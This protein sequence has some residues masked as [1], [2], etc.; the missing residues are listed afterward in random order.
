MYFRHEFTD[1]ADSLTNEITKMCLNLKTTEVQTYA[2]N[3]L[4]T[5]RHVS[6]EGLE[7]AVQCFTKQFQALDIDGMEPKGKIFYTTV[8]QLQSVIDFYKEIVLFEEFEDAQEQDKEDQ[9]NLATTLQLSDKEIARITELIERIKGLGKTK[10]VACVSFKEDSHTFTEFLSCFEFGTREHLNFHPELTLDKKIRIAK[11]MF[12]GP[13]ERWKQAAESSKIHPSVLMDF[14]LHN[15]LSSTGG[16]L[17]NFTNLLE[18]ICR[19]AD[20]EEVNLLYSTTYIQ[21]LFNTF[22]VKI[23]FENFQNDKD[24]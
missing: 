24:Y 13:L 18:V 23:I 17:T 9:E 11:L 22:T 16:T 3:T 2:I 8:L 1:S 15:W 14:A 10:E 6:P 12:R 7:V 5:S 21:R 4:M 20:V 19:L